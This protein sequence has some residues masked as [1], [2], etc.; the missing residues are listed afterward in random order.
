MRYKYVALLVLLCLLLAACGPKNVEK[1]PAPTDSVSPSNA[2]KAAYSSADAKTLLGSG[3][4]SEEPEL[5]EQDIAC[6]LFG[7]SA[8][9]VSECAVYLPTTTNA[10]ALVLF[11]LKDAQNAQS[12][13]EACEKWVAN[14]IESYRSYGPQHVPKLEGAVLTVRENSV[15]LA[16][17]ADPAATRTAVDG[18]DG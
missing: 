17:G 9:A 16:V 4:F 2:Q 13:K 11:V 12:V 10:E 5:L 6:E 1:S 3:I 8:D 18:L 7:V 14:Q 15:L